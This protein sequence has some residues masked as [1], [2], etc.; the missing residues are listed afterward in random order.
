MESLLHNL[1]I[2]SVGFF[3][4]IVHADN[5]LVKPAF[6]CGRVVAYWFRY[7]KELCSNCIPI[8]WSLRKF[9]EQIIYTWLFYVQSAA[10]KDTSLRSL[11]HEQWTPLLM[12][13]FR[14]LKWRIN[15]WALNIVVAFDCVGIFWLN[16][17]IAQLVT[18][19]TI[20]RCLYKAFLS[21]NFSPL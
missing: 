8:F 6:H 18:M 19:C 20:F 14:L 15:Q 16:Y 13:G 9:C 5:K 2:S 1:A 17:V 21:V 12:S 10:K 7:L 4:R 11:A 3:F